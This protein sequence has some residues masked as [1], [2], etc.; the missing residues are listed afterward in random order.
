[1]VKEYVPDKGDIIWLSFDPQSGKEITE[2]RPAVVMTPAIYNSKS[3]LCLVFPITSKVK[4][5]AFEVIFQEP[6]IQGAILADQIRSFDWRARKAQY[7]SKINPSALE[8]ALAKL[9]VLLS[10]HP[11]NPRC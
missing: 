10:Y 6:T 7:I 11:Q 9:N 3:G 1:M 5:L 2:T 4:G 8:D